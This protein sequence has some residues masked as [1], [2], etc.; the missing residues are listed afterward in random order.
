MTRM[1][2]S[3]RARLHGYFRSKQLLGE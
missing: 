3:C 2:V 1:A